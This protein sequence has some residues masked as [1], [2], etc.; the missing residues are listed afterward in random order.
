MQRLGA[1]AYTRI[2]KVAHNIADLAG[3]AQI[4]RAHIAQAVQYRALDRG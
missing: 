2:I 3:E 1:R 4:T